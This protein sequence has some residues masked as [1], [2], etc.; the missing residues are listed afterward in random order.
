MQI[1]K[2]NCDKCC[3]HKFSINDTK[4]NDLTYRVKWCMG[5]WYN[6]SETIILPNKYYLGLNKT[7]RYPELK[8]IMKNTSH[9]LYEHGDVCCDI[10][11]PCFTKTRPIQDKTNIIILLNFKRH[12]NKLKNLKKIDK[13][14]N[15]KKEIAIWRGTTTGNNNRPG[16]RFSLIEKWYNKL[17][18]IDVGFSFI[19]QNKDSYKKYVKKNMP[20]KKLLKYKYLICVEG[21]DVASGLK[22]MLY[23][24][25]VVLMPKPTVVSWFMEDHLVPFKHYIPIEND[26]SDLQKKIE[27]CKN[28]EEEC[29]T[30]IKNANKYVQR[31]LEEF[32]N[33]FAS[34]I[35]D[36]VTELY[37]KNI[38]FV[39]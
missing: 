22:W 32:H 29:K 34:C 33:G 13:P 12:W 39:T 21:N 38:S 28:N 15:A 31:F 37:R 35:H 20:I 25:S 14:F 2:W 16:N 36:K 24:Q 17:E 23:S 27:W 5:N 3:H 10:K 1:I 8:I 7:K 11:Y 26:W 6:N 4:L 18:H 9:F 30:I 19:C